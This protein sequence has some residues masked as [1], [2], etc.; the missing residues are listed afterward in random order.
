VDSEQEEATA[1]ELVRRRLAATAGLPAEVR[2]RRV[3][4]MLGRK[5]YSGGLAHR[6]VR[7]MIAAEGA[8]ASAGGRDRWSD[9]TDLDPVDADVTDHGAAELDDLDPLVLTEDG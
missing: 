9:A 7:E 8:D 2:T 6:L 4:A 1:R 5:G 3:V